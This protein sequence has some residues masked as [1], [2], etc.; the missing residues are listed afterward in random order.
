MTPIALLTALK[1]RPD[2]TNDGL[3]IL[4]RTRRKPTAR[5]SVRRIRRSRSVD[6]ISRTIDRKG[7]K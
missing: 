5:Y 7:N 1:A 3:E 6:V 2:A 4:N